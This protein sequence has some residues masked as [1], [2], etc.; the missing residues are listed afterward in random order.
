[1]FFNQAVSVTRFLENDLMVQKFELGKLMTLCSEQFWGALS[2]SYNFYRGVP[3][4]AK[5]GRII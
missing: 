4:L 1:M 5:D 3:L 2:P